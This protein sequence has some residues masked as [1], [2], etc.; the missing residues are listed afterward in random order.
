MADRLIDIVE[1][2][3][4]NLTLPAGTMTWQGPKSF[5]TIDLIFMTPFLQDRLIH[6]MDR[7]EMNQSSDHIPISTKLLLG[8]ESAPPG[9]TK[10]LEINQHG[11]IETTGTRCAMYKITAD[12]NRSRRVRGLDP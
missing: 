9:E 12:N 11:K 5:T 7:P 2:K 1:E 6:C 10:G 8:V 4:M 3:A